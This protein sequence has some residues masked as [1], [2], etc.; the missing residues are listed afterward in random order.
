MPRHRGVGVEDAPASQVHEVD[1][2][3][4]FLDDPPE[5]SLLLVGTL[6]R[7][8]VSQR[9]KSVSDV[10]GQFPQQA[11]FRCI[12]CVGLRRIDVEDHA[13]AAHL[14]R[15]RDRRGMAEAPGVLAPRREGFVAL[16]VVTDLRRRTANGP[17]SRTSPQVG[18]RPADLQLAQIRRID[19]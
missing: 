16:E 2:V 1:E 7:G 9:A 8:L 5:Q 14:E 6:V 3:T 10:R 19:A 17:T 11:D 12:E 13:V 15:Q 4:G 18:I